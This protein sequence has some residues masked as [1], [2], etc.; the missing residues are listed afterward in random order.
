MTNSTLDD[1]MDSIIEFYIPAIDF[2]DS[3]GFNDNVGEFL[4]TDMAE[5]IS[6]IR[7]IEEN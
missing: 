1:I 4:A 5:K 2:E 6:Q 7:E 3:N